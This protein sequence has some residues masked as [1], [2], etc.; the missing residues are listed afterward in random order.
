MGGQFVHKKWLLT[1]FQ[2]YTRT[3]VLW[4]AAGHCERLWTP[5]KT[6]NFDPR[7]LHGIPIEGVHGI[8]P[9]MTLDVMLNSPFVS[10]ANKRQFW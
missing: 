9:Y 6:G 1:N 10:Q 4:P 5:A 2:P 8:R 7:N 3:Q